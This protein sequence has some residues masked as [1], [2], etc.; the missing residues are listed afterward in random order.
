MECEYF[1]I[2][3][4][5][6]PGCIDCLYC[7]ERKWSKQAAMWMCKINGKLVAMMLV[8]LGFWI[9]QACSSFK[10]KPEC[11]LCEYY[12]YVFRQCT[13][14]IIRGKTLERHMH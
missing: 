9:S 6:C 1:K 12:D 13:H 14:P 10:W 7:Q 5:F 8:P 3:I 4:G 2:A 11:L